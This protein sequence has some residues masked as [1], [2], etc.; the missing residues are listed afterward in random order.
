MDSKQ[1]F[2]N[3][4]QSGIIHDD[5]DIS[6]IQEISPFEFVKKELNGMIGEAI[7]S[8]EHKLKINY[9][10]SSDADF[11]YCCMTT[12]QHDGSYIFVLE[13]I[14]RCLNRLLRLGTYFNEKLSPELCDEITY[15][16]GNLLVFDE[17]KPDLAPKDKKWMAQR[18]TVYLPVKYDVVKIREIRENDG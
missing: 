1:F 12:C 6:K 10:Y 7:I 4:L 5:V 2:I 8:K 13:T 18:T 16:F 9:L 17:Y 15:T 3:R 14:Q 11:D